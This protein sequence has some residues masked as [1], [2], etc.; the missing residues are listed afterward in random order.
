MVRIAKE[1]RTYTLSITNVET[2]DMYMNA[3]HHGKVID[4]SIVLEINLNSVKND[5]THIATVTLQEAFDG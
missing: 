3:L 4:G 1:P 5:T 2:L